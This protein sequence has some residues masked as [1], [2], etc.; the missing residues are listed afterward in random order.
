MNNKLPKFKEGK[1]QNFAKHDTKTLSEGIKTGVIKIH[2][3]S[4]PIIVKK[5]MSTFKKKG[6]Q[7]F[8][9]FGSKGSGKSRYC[10]QCAHILGTVLFND[11]SWKDT[12]NCMVFSRRDLEVKLS[13]CF[14][15]EG[16]IIKRWP[17]LI[18]DD[19][20]AHNQSTRKFD[21]YLDELSRMWQVI[22]SVVGVAIVNSPSFDVV[23]AKFRNA[24]DWV[25]IRITSYDS[26]SLRARPYYYSKSPIKVYLSPLYNLKGEQINEFFKYNGIP[27]DIIETYEDRRDGYAFEMFN[28]LKESR[29]IEEIKYK[30]V[31]M[32]AKRIAQELNNIENSSSV[33]E[34]TKRVKAMQ[35]SAVKELKKLES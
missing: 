2:K 11:W 28:R 20:G 13:Q 35:K 7:Q 16:K 18:L 9:V 6:H 33:D 24:G 25:L 27:D 34:V 26:S 32:G 29:Q 5:G 4:L 21:E 22:R 30:A 31:Q 3:P 17:I 19:F 14:N 10:L 15:A 12:L 1:K 8:F 23:S